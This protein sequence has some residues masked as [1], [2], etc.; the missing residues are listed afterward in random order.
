MSVNGKVSGLVI[1]IFLLGF[2]LSAA[3][4]SNPTRKVKFKGRTISCADLY[5]LSEDVN[6]AGSF[7]RL[8]KQA[9]KM[10]AS[11]AEVR[12]LVAQNERWNKVNNALR[13]AVGVVNT[14]YN[15]FTSVVNYIK[16]GGLLESF[17]GLPSWN[18]AVARGLAEFA[19]GNEE[20]YRQNKARLESAMSMGEQL[21]K[22]L[23]RQSNQ[24]I[25][26]LMDAKRAYNAKCS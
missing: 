10:K 22:S 17:F 23:Y 2:S 26:G 14:S 5:K 12:K 18:D 3:A 15:V 19:N 11:L 1:G 16:G 9:L 25:Q 20:L 21:F 6:A 7:T 13:T 8:R 4:Q 24:A